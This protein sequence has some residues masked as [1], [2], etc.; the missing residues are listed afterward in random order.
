ME[1]K[2]KSELEPKPKRNGNWNQYSNQY[3]SCHLSFNYISYSPSFYYLL[4][5]LG[6]SHV[7][8]LYNISEYN[9][10]SLVAVLNFFRVPFFLRR[11]NFQVSQPNKANFYF[12]FFLFFALSLYFWSSLAL[13]LG[14]AE[15]FVAH[16]S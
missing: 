12:N 8:H 14:L 10:F 7:Q 9:I 6:Y 1:L 13:S 11:A 3:Q 2:K 16:N 5:C 4:L 15:V